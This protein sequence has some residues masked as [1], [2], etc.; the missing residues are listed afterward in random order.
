M[1]ILDYIPCCNAA[2]ALRVHHLALL[3]GLRASY[4]PSGGD[5]AQTM[6][7]VSHTVWVM[8][9]PKRVQK[10]IDENGHKEAS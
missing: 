2:Q 4:H 8:G 7:A 6:R 9:A 5:T 10:F 1:E 3:Q